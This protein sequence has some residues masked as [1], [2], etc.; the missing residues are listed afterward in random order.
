MVQSKK[1][2][3]F[4]FA[5]IIKEVD[6]I[7]EL[8][9]SKQ[10]QKQAIIDD[11]EKEKKRYRVGKISESTLASSVR[12]TNDGFIKIDKEIRTAIASHNRLAD[13]AKRMASNQ[14]PK[15]FRA[16]LYGVQGN[17]KASKKRRSKKQGSKKQRPKKQKL[18]PGIRRILEEER[19]LDR[20]Y[21][22]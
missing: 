10:D 12:K 16:H 2:N 1:M 9:R 19:K 7:A 21:Q 13:S 18:M 14:S 11:F 3:Q 8:I 20:K 22:K 15:V 4:A 5:K 6:S 17:K